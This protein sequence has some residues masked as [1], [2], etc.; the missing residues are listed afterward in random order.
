MKAG[1]K[2]ALGHMLI[3]FPLV[4]L[5]GAGISVFLTNKIV[6]LILY[7]L[8]ALFLFYFGILQFKVRE[9]EFRSSDSSR[10]FGPLISGI[11]FTLFNPYFIIWWL[12]IGGV[13]IL[14]TILLLGYFGLP[15]IYVTHVWMDYAWL[16]FI[17]YLASIGRRRFGWRMIKYVNV[18]LGVI[19]M[20]FGVTFILESINIIRTLQL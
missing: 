16:G 15:L 18:V 19:M 14:N 6:Q 3:E 11:T 1:L 17:A 5:L 2:T 12:T 7:I 20:Y 4:M 8:G 10:Y 13:I 9:I